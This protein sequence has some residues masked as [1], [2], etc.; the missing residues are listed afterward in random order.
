MTA[1]REAER[2]L[3][4]AESRLQALVEQLPAITYIEDPQTGHNM[5][6]SPQIEEMYGYTAAEWTADPG[7]W[8]RCLHPD[9]RD[10]VMA[11]N[12][13]DNGDAWSVDYRSISKAG[14]TFWVH[15]EARLIRD[16]DGQPLYWLGLAFDIT[17]R[18]NAEGRLREAEERY[19]ALV[20]QLPV[21]VYTD[22]VD[23]VSTALYISPRYEQLTGYSPEQRLLDGVQ[24]TAQA[25]TGGR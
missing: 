13:A 12:A 1:R 17:E 7:L 11:S 5:Y 22:A 4:A 6:I 25:S 3:G 24:A 2:A 14:R 19:R 8:T 21:A 16:E 18:K 10:W 23:D 9:D 15:N 20:E